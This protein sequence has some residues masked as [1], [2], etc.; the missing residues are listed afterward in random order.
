VRQTS[1]RSSVKHR[2]LHLV[3]FRH[4]DFGQQQS[5]VQCLFGQ[6]PNQLRVIIMLRNVAEHQSRN[7]G[8]QFFLQV[9]CDQ[10]VGKMAQSPHHS[11][12]DTPRIRPDAK[13]LQIVVAFQQQKIA[14]PQMET[15]R[16]RQVPQIGDQR[17]LDALRTYGIR[18]GIGRIVRN[19]KAID[20]EI[21]DFQASAGLEGFDFRLKRAPIDERRGAMGQVNRRVGELGHSD[22]PADVIGMFMGHENRIEL[23]RVFA[24]LLQSLADFPA[25]EARVDQDS[26]F[27]RANER[28]IAGAASGEDANLENRPTP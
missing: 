18:H 11:L 24:D 10:V 6:H 2:C 21:A 15:D 28:R 14:L 5:T 23:G 1:A 25:A 4:D 9:F 13:H 27:V 19:R 17:C 22:Q 26:R 3:G 8:R 7:V 12:L 16:L 20:A